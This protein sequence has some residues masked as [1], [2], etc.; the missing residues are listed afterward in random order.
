ME[1]NV[2]KTRKQAKTP[3][4]RLR[5]RVRREFAN[6]KYIGDIQ[7]S[8]E[9][10]DILLQYLHIAFKRIKITR[11]HEVD[12]PLFAVALVQIGIRNYNGKFWPYVSKYID[13]GITPVQQGWIGRSFVNILSK[14][15][16]IHLSADEMVNN[17]LM[18]SFITKYYAKDFFD[19]LFAQETA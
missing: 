10:Y 14:Y 18:H 13:G 19:F 6:V 8:D 12:D 5:N 3:Y 4:E 15:N 9:E 16:K 2:P 1:N 17:I 7:I 11:S